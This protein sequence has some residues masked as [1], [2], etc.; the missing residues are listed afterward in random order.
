MEKGVDASCADVEDG[1]VTSDAGW[2]AGGAGCR[3]QAAGGA[4]GEAE[5]PGAPLVPAS[6]SSAALQLAND[7]LLEAA[8]VIRDAFGTGGGVTTA[9]YR[10]QGTD[11]GVTASVVVATGE[12]AVPPPQGPGYTVQGTGY[13]APPPQAQGAKPPEAFTA[14]AEPFTEPFTAPA[15]PFTALAE[16]PFIAPPEKPFTAA[17]EEEGLFESCEG[18]DGLVH[19]LIKAGLLGLAA[20]LAISVPNFGYVV[21]LMGSVT[22]MVMSFILPAACNLIVHH[23]TH[24]VLSLAFNVAI[25]GV[26]LI[27]MVAGV[28]STLAQG[29]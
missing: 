24:G 17:A 8:E 29:A 11:G 23:H 22:C 2:V 15:E 21:S 26:G 16:H 19:T 1:C 25:I 7:L 3:V 9:G 20:L 10:V 5:A 6:Q 28:Q 18:V 13:T 4:A 27:G 14:P 12:P